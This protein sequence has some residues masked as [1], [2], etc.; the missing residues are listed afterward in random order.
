M[1]PLNAGGRPV[2]KLVRDGRGRLWLGGD[3]LAVLDADGRTLH[4]LDELPILGRQFKVEALAADAAKADG[5][6]VAI[7]GRGVVF[8]SVDKR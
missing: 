1:P 4:P 2:S 3:G 8:L 7:E 5:A 6:I